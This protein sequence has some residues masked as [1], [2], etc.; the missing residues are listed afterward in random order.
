MNAVG[1]LPQPTML[2]QDC[3]WMGGQLCPERPLLLGA[4]GGGA[5]GP[6][7]RH[8]LPRSRRSTTKRFTLERLTANRRA[9]ST[10]GVPAST[11]ATIRDRRS[12]DSA[13]IRHPALGSIIQA[14]ALACERRVLAR[15]HAGKRYS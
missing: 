9:T 12:G 1:R 10:F 8:Q 3:R 6:G 5:A 11:A 7:Q 2:R 13:C 14:T 4:D 15:G